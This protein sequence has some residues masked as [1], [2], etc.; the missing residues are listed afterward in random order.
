M[1][2]ERLAFVRQ[3]DSEMRE[4]KRAAIVLAKQQKER[5][6]MAKVGCAAHAL[7]I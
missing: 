1:L 6:L 5:E 3:E 7:M 2:Q 4:E